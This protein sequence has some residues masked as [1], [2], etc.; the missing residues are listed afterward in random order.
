MSDTQTFGPFAFQVCKLPGLEFFWGFGSV[1][2]I[3][4]LQKLKCLVIAAGLLQ[5][6]DASPMDRLF[7]L[8]D[9]PAHNTS[10]APYQ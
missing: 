7:L 2:A 9:T 3:A 4:A 1:L 6:A 10:W 5:R 8:Y